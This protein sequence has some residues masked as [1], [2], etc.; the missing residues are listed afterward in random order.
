MSD[1]KLSV[2]KENQYRLT[3]KKLKRNVTIEMNKLL[4]DIIEMVEQK[5]YDLPKQ[6]VLTTNKFPISVKKNIFNRKKD[7]PE[8]S[9]PDIIIDVVTESIFN[10]EK[11]L[12][13]RLKDIVDGHSAEQMYYLKETLI[14]MDDFFDFLARLVDYDATKIGNEEE[15]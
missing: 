5:E 10:D 3:D 6:I 14:Q 7:N 2:Y 11:G 13:K 12:E 15:E 8:K 4:P 9:F 1:M